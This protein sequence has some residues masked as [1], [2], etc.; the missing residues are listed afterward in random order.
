MENKVALE[1]NIFQILNCRYNSMSNPMNQTKAFGFYVRSEKEEKR[2][3]KFQNIFLDQKMLHILNIG[4][5]SIN[6]MLYAISKRVIWYHS[7]RDLKY[8]IYIFTKK[9][10]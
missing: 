10:E 3:L 1:V 7:Y 9:C 4:V 8:R 6:D 2:N 5:S